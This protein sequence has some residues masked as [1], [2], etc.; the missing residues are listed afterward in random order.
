MEVQI[1]SGK[2][3][4]MKTWH[5][6]KESLYRC[7]LGFTLILLPLGAHAFDLSPNV[8]RVVSD[9]SYLPSGGQFSGSTE[10]SDSVI[11][12]NTND[13]SGTQ[14]STTNTIS[15]AVSQVWEFGLTGDFTLRFADAYQWSTPTSTAADG[16]IS[17][18]NYEGFVDPSFGIIWR[19]LD[20]QEHFFN[21]DL[22]AAYAPN[23]LNAQSADPT[24]NGT[25]ARGGDTAS[26]GTA[27]SY[28]GEDFTLYLSGTATCLDNRSILNPGSNITVDYNSSWQYTFSVLTQTRVTNKWS[29]NLGL[30]R[31]YIDNISGS[32]T[33]NNGT[34]FII[35]DQPGDVTTFI[36][37]LN[38]QFAPN[39]F[40]MSIIYNYDFFDNGAFT[41]VTLPNN[42]TT[43]TD[44]GESVYGLEFR[45]V[46]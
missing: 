29:V 28:K 5:R 36:A 15:D 12:F 4:S 1:E 33:T 16:S 39:R 2:T 13:A 3:H 46:L 41:N 37:A 11:N 18:T 7:G 45:Y 25:V 38:L 21:W 20:E 30:S 6:F 31:L 34:L 8:S 27:L 24:Q 23:F 42:S 9:P 17:I 26:F 40:V 32:F 10:Y 14:T 19:V 22:T 44:K 43:T 35:G